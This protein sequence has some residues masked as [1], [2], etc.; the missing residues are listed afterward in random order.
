MVDITEKFL[1]GIEMEK[2]EALLETNEE[3]LGREIKILAKGENN[4]I[5]GKTGVGKSL[6]TAYI[7]S[8]FVYKTCNWFLK[9][10]ENL[11]V[12]LMDSEQGEGQIKDWFIN[13]VFREMDN[14]NIK[15]LESFKRYKI[16]SIK[17]EENKLDALK[18]C[19]DICKK[20]FP[21]MHLLIVIDNLTSFVDNTNDS[22]NTCLNT[23]N[24]YRGENT[25]IS[26]VHVNDKNFE[27]NEATGHIGSQA[28][29]NVSMEWHITR[30]KDHEETIE[31]TC[32]KSRFDDHKKIPTLLL[33][34]KKDK[35]LYINECKLI[36][37][38]NNIT[39][40][41]STLEK[42]YDEFKKID[43]SCEIES[44]DRLRK[45]VKD[46]LKNILNLRE[47]MIYRHL[48]TLKEQG[49]IFIDKNDRL[50]IQSP[51]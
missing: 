11:A 49:R 19:I 4:I 15:L 50:Y 45:N 30:S 25:L 14:E 48:G 40:K 28:K 26:I 29:R 47:A 42:V 18:K 9:N 44:D 24:K 46:K 10:N 32:T 36:D 8:Q 3:E 1:L 22:S 20:L 2:K 27:N 37:Q 6:V 7:I 33:S 23:I 51:F 21:N 43:E 38:S 41:P 39:K 12:L 13:N 5:K 17:D 34:I 16:F 35:T 31:M